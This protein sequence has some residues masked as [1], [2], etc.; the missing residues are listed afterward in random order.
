MSTAAA[1]T[2]FNVLDGGADVVTMA[3]PAFK[4]IC[5]LVAP[6]LP[7]AKLKEGDR[8]Q[9]ATL[10]I[11]EQ[12]RPPHM[13]R[14]AHDSLQ[15]RFD[16]NCASRAKLESVGFITSF[17]PSKWNL[18]SQ[19]STDARKLHQRAVASSHEAKSKMLWRDKDRAGRSSPG[20][21]SAPVTAKGK[22]AHPSCEISVL[23]AARTPG[24]MNVTLPE[25]GMMSKLDGGEGMVTDMAQNYSQ[26][27]QPFHRPIAYPGLSSTSS[28]PS[29]WSL[30]SEWDELDADPRFQDVS[31][32][33][34]SDSWSTL[35]SAAGPAKAADV[36]SD[37]F[38]GLMQHPV[39][40]VSKAKLPT[41]GLPALPSLSNGPP[42][43]LEDYDVAQ[44]LKPLYLREWFVTWNRGRWQLAKYIKF[45][46]G[47]G[48]YDFVSDVMQMCFEEN[49]GTNFSIVMSNMRSVLFSTR[50]DN[51]LRPEQHYSTDEK[52][53]R[54]P[55][56]TLRDVRLALII[57]RHWQFLFKEKR[58]KPRASL[59]Q[60]ISS[61]Y[62]PLSLI[63][64]TLRPPEKRSKEDLLV[65]HAVLLELELITIPTS[66]V[67]KVA[68]LSTVATLTSNAMYYPQQSPGI[69]HKLPAHQ[70]PN[71]VHDQSPWSRQPHHAV[72]GAPA[73]TQPPT[74]PG[75]PL[76]NGALS[77]MQHHPHPHLSGPLTHHHHHQNSLSHSH[78][79]SPPNG[80][81]LQGHVALNGSP[82]SVST[83]H[84]TV[85]WQ[86]QLLKY[87]MSRASRSPHHRARA[88]AM[89]SR[90]VQK[91]AIP[92]TNPNAVK[93]ADTNGT[94]VKE[95]DGTSGSSPS[96]ASATT[97]SPTSLSASANG[98][99]KGADHPSSTVAPVVE[100]PRPTAP[101]PQNT[102]S[103]L[104]M[105]GV[106]IKSLPPSSGLFSFSFLI[107]LYLNH[108]A[109]TSIPPEIAKLRHLELLDLSGNS[110]LH[111]P[112]E[113]GMLTSL[114]ELYL[115]DNQLTTL[116]PELGTLHQ[117]QTLGIEGNPLELSL[118]QIVQK[119][120][121][122]ALIS[123]LRDSC[124]VSASPPDRIWKDLITT[125]ERESLASDPNV[126][127]LSALCYNILCERCAT[128]RLYGYTPSWALAWDYRKE[129]ILAEIVG[130][131]A[132]FVCLQEVDI[133]Q[134]EDYF[135][136]NLSERDYEGVYW[137]KSRYK[138][139]NEADRRLVDG[140]ATFYKASKYTLVEKHLIEFSAVAMQRSDFKKT[141]DMFNRVLGKDHIAVISLLENKLTGTRFIIANAHIHWDPQYRDVK[142]V[143]A[144]L[145]VEE[146]EKI[147]DSFAKYPPRPPISTNGMTTT[148]GAGDHNAS[149]RPPPIY[150]DGTKIP[151]IICGDFNSVPASGVYDFLS[152]GTVPHN[153]PDFMSHLYGKYTSD[154]LKHRLGLKSAYA[155]VGELPLT[156]FTPS[157]YG[158][159][160]YIWYSTANLSVNAVLGE[161]D[162]SYLEKVVGF[163]NP[164]FPSDHLCIVSEFRVRPPKDPQAPRPPP[165]FPESS[166]AHV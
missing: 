26:A 133:A 162:K 41:D 45:K 153:H 8:A 51:A 78:F 158:A 48:T 36:L 102:W 127:T 92:I 150:S 105:G 65:A 75:Y 58:L 64:F 139:M 141:D 80:N 159:I 40:K 151:L 34:F 115:F 88:S 125:A 112:T 116:P 132:D 55:G 99:A 145:L 104:D 33:S 157:F 52:P 43:I 126:E 103:S 79:P 14:E 67:S 122:P 109:L 155:A 49:L 53:P 84:M 30:S 60:S 111:I 100:V 143:Q 123:Y 154:G 121:T 130:H 10:Q 137:P 134:Y 83:P 4:P 50:T 19:Y 46:S 87:E 44:Y 76:F 166:R 56:I 59:D 69:A 31:G 42:V 74:S 24:D 142:L 25:E 62:T 1:E 2:F 22:G 66:S 63:P 82:G 61:V 120:G 35:E 37:I 113:L 21:L 98:T 38:S 39:Q 152:T 54:H 28:V 47:T 140:C 11:L 3:T 16:K 17:A 138:T 5:R 85:H 95:N 119:D 89:A 156:N 161:V 146:I 68:T 131:D 29:P 165:I 91:S 96:T 110:L 93:P 90:T 144:A 164:H 118:K 136:R 71:Q 147:A 32:D 108:N 124:P 7:P 12:M 72:L 23:E 6:L 18:I 101:K 94:I 13:D 106:N 77:A 114:K 70:H 57:E 117:L 86:Q 81:G 9:A 148:S 15:Q 160:D 73:H 149:S 135:L 97:S 129:L 27:A 163:P 128:E 20:S 107:N